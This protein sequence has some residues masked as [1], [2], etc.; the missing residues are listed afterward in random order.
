MGSVSGGFLTFYDGVHRDSRNR[1]V[2]HVAH[3]L[4][5]LGILTLFYNI[6]LGIILV[7]MAFPI[8]WLGHYLF[9]KNTPAFFDAP[10]RHLF[11]ASALKKTQV[12]LGGMVWSAW[13]L[14]RA[15]RRRLH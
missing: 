9:E 10:S 3:A 5:L 11:G 15:A 4:A 7:L 8:S 12:A 14:W 13:C 1:W 6:P 2:H